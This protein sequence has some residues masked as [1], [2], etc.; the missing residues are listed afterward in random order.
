MVQSSDRVCPIP[1]R[2]EED[3]HAINGA[4]FDFRLQI[5]LKEVVDGG[6]A[7]YRYFPRCPSCR[8]KRGGIQARNRWK[9]KDC[10]KTVEIVRVEVC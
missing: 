5:G 3:P 6:L 1:P 9:C 7:V 10:G 4:K 8:S 2:P